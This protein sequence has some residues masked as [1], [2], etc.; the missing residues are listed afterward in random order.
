MFRPISVYI[1][2]R[3]MRARKRG[4]F[5]SFISLLSMLGIALG[6]IVLITILSVVNGFDREI[7]KQLFGMIAPITISSYTNQID[8]WKTLQRALQT[9]PDITG[10]APF[11]SGQALLTNSNITQP[12][13]IT[14]I[15]PEQEKQVSDLTNKMVQGKLAAL[16][17]NQFGIVLG[18]GLAKKLQ[19]GIGDHIILATPQSSYAST[20]I[21]AGFHQFVVVG[22]FH[23][24]GGGFGFDAKYAFIH[25]SDAQNVFHRGSGVSA[26]HVNINDIYQAPQISN[27]LQ[28]EFASSLRV[29]NWTELLGDFFE[30]IRMTK[31]MMFFIFVLIIT[32]AVFNLICTLVLVVKNKQGDI[33]I[34][35]TL[36]ATPATILT[37][38]VVQGAA[39][40][41]GGIALGIAGGVALAWNIPAISTWIQS[42]FH[43]ELISANV[44]FVNYLPSELQWHD[45]WGI[46][47]IA[48]VLSLLATLYPAWNAAR[49][50]PAEALNN[51]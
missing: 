45:V 3:Y 30:N 21:K 41:L 10:V 42:T 13:M 19:V 28:T 6:V 29:N 44:Y 26:L 17:P 39:I 47:V 27:V 14:G 34:L 2:L 15:L 16:A 37:I 8:D 12:A 22:I 48:L 49:V 25:L 23:A 33:A 51:E 46:S 43:L 4:Q 40:G 5:V 36:G 7:K 9:S 50:V 31:T 1:G 24:G 38:F 32:V 35:R 20:H 18:E 11:V